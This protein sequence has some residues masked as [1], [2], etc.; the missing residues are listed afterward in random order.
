[1][2]MDRRSFL[3]L[4]A[5]ALAAGLISP[6]A[7]AVAPR[8]TGAEQLDVAVS[9]SGNAADALRLPALLQRRGMLLALDGSLAAAS[10]LDS[11]LRRLPPAAFE[12]LVVLLVLPLRD[13]AQ[14]LAFDAAPH[15]GLR[16][17]RVAAAD[18]RRVAPG[19][20][21]PQLFGFADGGRLRLQRM[22]T[23]AQQLGLAPFHEAL[24]KEIGG[25]P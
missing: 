12:E 18:W 14:P 25:R 13:T 17:A 20:L 19:P 2:T 7:H 1:M 11:E 16:V 22:D 4:T 15:A 6:A 10:W 23:S 24:L 3:H 8:I 5:P 9:M 21:L